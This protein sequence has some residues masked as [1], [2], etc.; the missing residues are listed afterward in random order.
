MAGKGVLRLS[1][2]PGGVQ[3][4]LHKER[5][6]NLGIVP[7]PLPEHLVLPLKASFGAALELLVQAGQQVAR[8][9]LL[10]APVDAIGIPVHAPVDA[11]VLEIAPRHLPHPAAILSPC[12]VLTPL[13]GEASSQPSPTMAPCPPEAG[14]AE[15]LTRIHEAGINGMGGAGFP[16]AIK[17]SPRHPIKSL[18]LN[19]VECEPYITAD[20]ALMR[21]R[22]AEIIS[23]AEIL[24]QLLDAEEILIA[25][26]DNKPE[27]AAALRAA[28]AEAP[29]SVAAQIVITPT[30]YPAGG[31]KQLVQ[32]LT[33]REVPSGGLPAEVGAACQNVATAAAIY[34]AVRLG[35]VLLSRIV[36]V[37]GAG[38]ARPANYETLIGTPITTLLEASGARPPDDSRIVVGGPMMGVSVPPDAPV[39]KTTSGILLSVEPQDMQ[40]AEA[41]A[42]I[43]CGFCAEVCPASLLPQ[44]LYWFARSREEDKAQRHNLFDCIEC[45]ACAYVCPSRIP[46]VQYY[47]AAKGAIR[48]Q[49]RDQKQADSARDRFEANQQRLERRREEQKERRRQRREKARTSADSKQDAVIRAAVERT[50]G[51]DGDSQEPPPTA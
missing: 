47:R 14:K 29:T 25:I 35:E 42:C 20:E 8:G 18:I 4:P 17:L 5:T 21:E 50:R 11:T 7:S 32:E 36:T 2:V 49:Q 48:Q 6:R 41:M 33:G 10:A 9:Q 45:G 23:G 39:L 24:A 26:E 51:D 30:R 38:V 44:Q 22:P 15:V 37:T 1:P 46:L 27:A 31:E 40:S 3:L 34:R 43:R 13:P 16:S 19:G 28:L 12:I